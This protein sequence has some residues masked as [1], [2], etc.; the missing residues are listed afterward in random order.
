[1]V[2]RN[3]QIVSLATRLH[4]LRTVAPEGLC[5]Y[6]VQILWSHHSEDGVSARQKAGVT[7]RVGSHHHD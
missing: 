1:M 7:L 4:Q 2:I 6:V 5:G 3:R